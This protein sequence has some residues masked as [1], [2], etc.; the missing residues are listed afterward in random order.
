MALYGEVEVAK[1]EVSIYTRRH[2]RPMCLY[3]IGLKL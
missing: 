1:L 3:V 2:N